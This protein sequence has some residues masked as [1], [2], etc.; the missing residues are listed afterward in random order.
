MHI[1][2][3]IIVYGELEAYHAASIQQESEIALRPA[4]PLVRVATEGWKEG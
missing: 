1:T 3:I 2:V 4:I